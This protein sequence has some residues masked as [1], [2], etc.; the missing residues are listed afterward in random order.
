MPS[1]SMQPTLNVGDYIIVKKLGFGG[2][3]T[4]GLSLLNT[5]IS[6]NTNI[7]RGKVY[8]FYPPHKDVPFVKR[9][10]A[11]PGDTVELQG[12]QLFVNGLLLDTT[13]MY[14]TEFSAVYE[15]T[16]DKTSY[17]IQRISRRP[18][19]VNKKIVVPANNYFFLGDNRD[20]SM[21]SRVWGTVANDRF[22]GEVVHVFSK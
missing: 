2:Y 16:L 3:G 22:L 17:L 9:L 11:I 7:Q 20:N 5:G 6:E 15:E 1:R 19:I 4:F 13:L 18:S 12:K 21:D 14:E 10:I 8:V